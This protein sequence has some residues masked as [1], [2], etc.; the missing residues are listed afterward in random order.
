MTDWRARAFCRGQDTRIWFD[1]QHAEL[2]LK[3]CAAC[4]VPC[5][6]LRFALHEEGD[7]R[8]T[9]RAGI[10]GGLRAADRAELARNLKAVA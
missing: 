10:F 2:A 6:C 1:K 5:E 7:V 9:W 4:P 3:F 8:G